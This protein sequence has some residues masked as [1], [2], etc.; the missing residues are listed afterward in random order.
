MNF[1]NCPAVATM[2]LCL[3]APTQSLHP[4]TESSLSHLSA[5]ASGWART[6]M[7]CRGLGGLDAPGCLGTCPNP[8]QFQGSQTDL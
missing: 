8:P 1:L 7:G 3:P 4:F 6:S 2:A 5:L